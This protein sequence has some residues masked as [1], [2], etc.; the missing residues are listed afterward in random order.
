MTTPQKQLTLFVTFSILP[1]HIPAWLT[2]HR[3]VW[4][5]VAT[6]PRCLLFD[7]FQDPDSPG[8]FRL[9][10]VW[11]C[12][13]EWFENVQLKKEY[14]KTLWEQTEWMY[15]GERR[16]EYLERFGEGCVFRERYLEGGKKMG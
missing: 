7:V 4:S 2:A 13:K 15:E 3:I 5:H 10:E 9:V 11:D 8:R 1:T 14:Y 12:D 6:E 16:I